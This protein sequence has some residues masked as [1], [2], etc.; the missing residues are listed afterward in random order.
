MEEIYWPLPAGASQEGKSLSERGLRVSDKPAEIEIYTLL[1]FREYT[2]DSVH[3]NIAVPA[4]GFEMDYGNETLFQLC[5]SARRECAGDPDVDG[6][7]S[8]R[9][10]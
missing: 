6:R 2:Q 1:L 8:E 7:F 9:G 4:V 3:R 10:V 5:R